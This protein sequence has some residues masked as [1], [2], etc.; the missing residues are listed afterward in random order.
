MKN[1][2]LSLFICLVVITVGFLLSWKSIP[3][4]EGYFEAAWKLSHLDFSK[5]LLDPSVTPLN[6]L[7]STLIERS[8]HISLTNAWKLMDLF[9]CGLLV[10]VFTN[11]YSK[12]SFS[13]FSFQ[14]FVPLIISLSSLGFIYSF[15][16]ASGEGMPIFFSV[17]GVYLWQKRSFVPANLLFILA[18]LSKY[19][20]Y[21]IAPGIFLWT[22]FNFKTFTKKDIQNMFFG[23][24]LLVSILVLYHGIKHWEEIKLQLRYVNNTSPLIFINNFAIYL[25]AALLGAPL[26]LLFTFLNPQINNLFLLTAISSMLI[27]SRRYFYWNH[28]QQIVSFLLLF[29]FTHPKAREFLQLRSVALQVLFTFI[30]I[31]F[32]PITA[33][34]F[35]LFPK[36]LTIYESQAVDREIMKDFHGGNIGYYL[37]R[38]FDEPFPNYEISYMDPSWDF[39]MDDTEY[40]VLPLPGIPR[41]LTSFKQCQYIFHQQVGTN[42]IYKVMCSKK[43]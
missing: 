39:V 37:N 33:G 2:L 35:T 32:L 43:K 29:L 19:T 20:F 21:L 10:I 30:I 22:L 12:S 23:I 31:I 13:H 28:V 5:S 36:Q 8:L 18:L 42:S 11:I 34:S 16:S 3:N 38:R 41:Q 9:F 17:V 27:L 14:F 15:T 6:F 24:S 25:F 26:L 4:Q 7:V 1:L 40:V